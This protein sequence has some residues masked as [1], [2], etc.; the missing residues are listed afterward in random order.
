MSGSDGLVY[1]FKLPTSDDI[2]LTHNP[3]VSQGD[4]GHRERSRLETVFR[5]RGHVEESGLG[6]GETRVLN[7]TWH[8]DRERM[9]I[10][11]ANDGGIHVWQYVD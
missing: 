5:H 8:K 4:Q 9:V 2:T 3:S 6:T 11:S 10:S 7:H 1:I